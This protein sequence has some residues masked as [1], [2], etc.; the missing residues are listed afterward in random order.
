MIIGRHRGGVVSEC[1][2]HNILTPYSAALLFQRS[3]MSSKVNR[4]RFGGSVR[5]VVVMMFG[6]DLTIE[7]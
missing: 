7:Q 5:S 1:V 2:A 6:R 4:F 3:K